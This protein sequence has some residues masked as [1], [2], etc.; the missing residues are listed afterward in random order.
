M[1]LSLPVYVEGIRL[2]GVAPVFLARP[3]FF[4]EPEVRGE[5]LDRVLMRLARDL[6]QQLTRLGREGRHEFLAAY[7]FYPALSQQRLQLTLV[8]RRHTVRCRLP[9]VVFRQFGR[10]LA[11]SPKV[12]EVWFDLARS[13]TL[14][15]RAT[16]VLTRHFRERER[17]EA[18]LSVEGLTLSGTAYVTPLEIPVH[19]PTRPP[20]ARDERFLALG[21]DAP[22]DGAGELR[23]VGRCLDW[24]Y[25]DDLDRVHLRDAEIAELTRLLDG[26][27]QRPVLLVGPR[28]VGKTAL[29]HEYVYRGV[30]RRASPFRDR[31]NVWLLAPA[32]LI[33]GMS[34]VGQWENRLLAILKEARR[35]QHLLYF[36][37]L[38]GLFHAG[39]TCSSPLSVAGVLKPYL[40]RRQVR[41]LA[42]ITPEALRVL[43]EQDRAFAD[44][45]HVLPVA[46]PSEA[47]TLRIVIAVQRLLEGKHGCLFDLDVLPAAL[48]LQRRYGRGV[49]FPGKAATF[50]RQLAVKHTGQAVRRADALEEFHVRSGLSLSFLDEQVRLERAEVLKALEKDVLGQPAA[51]AAAADVIAVAKA[52]LNDPDRPLAAFLFLG[53]TGVGKTQC[54]KAIAAYLFGDAERL[55][56]FDLNEYAAPGAAARLVGTF[57]QP[58]GLLTAAMRRQPFAV[59]LFDEVEKAHPEVFDL[60]L[61]VLGEGR[62]TDALGRTVDFG[63]ALIVLTSNLGVRESEG[64]LGFRQD[65]AATDALFVEAAQRFFR[66][67]FFNRL[68]RVLPFR[69]LTRDHVRGIAEKLVGEVFGREGLAQRKCLLHVEEPALERIVD[70]GFDPV[71]GARAL[72]RSIERHLTQPVAAQLAALP[73]GEFTAVRVYPGPEQLAVRVQVLEQVTPRPQPALNLEDG[74]GLLR[75]VRAVVRRIEDELAPLKP[76]GPVTLGQVSPEQYRYFLVREQLERVRDRGRELK[77]LFDDLP[78]TQRA[79]PSYPNTDMRS[80]HPYKVLRQLNGA[81]GRSVLR[82]LA[83]ALSIHEYLRELALAATPQGTAPH[84]AELLAL[85]RQV[86]LLQVMADSLCRPTPERV[87]MWAPDWGLFRHGHWQDYRTAL[88]RLHLEVPPAAIPIKDLPCDVGPYLTVQGL[89]AWPV[90]QPEV[91]THLVCF[92]HG[93]IHALQVFVLPLDAGTEPVAFLRDWLQRRRGWLDALARGAAAVGDDPFAYGPVVR[94]RGTP[95]GVIDLRTGLTAETEDITELLLAA[96]P[97]PPELTARED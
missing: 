27:E 60:L 29:V 74:L 39:Q 34:F 16:E 22:M 31:R 26:P 13:E 91:G 54:A 17:D 67:E 85:V 84:A 61:Q 9:F 43:R 40:E 3:L 8:L 28:Q 23:R 86:A 51:L 63:N 32:R 42:E 65:D 79:L 77:V 20:K 56:R 50:L 2:P 19:L 96:L 5:K 7:T 35:R 83:G 18:D 10:R 25:P 58:E 47:D 88:E 37:D 4:A 52:R 49:A 81:A 76:A 89:H 64:T 66:P 44:L 97:L 1:N 62:L 15:D 57:N 55:L 70:Q 12:P 90:T 80:G 14:R 87:V 53:P 94:I 59:I 69:R 68:D 36:D 92:D 6:G 11:F 95:P 93:V 45:F 38:L 82:E 30:G 46:E 33:S 73:P 71:L 24:Q 48:D 72:K 41:I 78:R 21:D 75:R